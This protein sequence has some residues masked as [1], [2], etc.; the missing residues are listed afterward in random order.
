M[1]RLR[2]GI[3]DLV[4]KSPRPSLYGR[5]MNANLASIMPQVVAVWCEELGHDVTLVCYTGIEDLGRE[6]PADLDLL[7]IGAF[8][9]SAQLAYSLSNLYRSRGAVTA[10]G[11]P[12]ARCYP[13]DAQ[14]YFDY[15]L[16]FT[17]RNAIDE[18]LRDCEPHRPMGVQISAPRQPVELPTLQRRWK[19]VEAT[20]AKAPTIKI[21]PM[22]GSLGCPYTCCFC[23]DSTVEYQPLS[24]AQMSAD[25]KFLLTKFRNPIVGWHDPNFG[26]RFNDYMDAIEAAVPRGR[27]R[28]IAESSLSL[29]S[30]PHLQRLRDNGF[31][32]ILP[33][34]E[35]WYDLG[36]KSKTRRTGMD[37]VRQV[38][39]HVNMILRYIPY[40]QTN[41][42]LGMDT[43]DGPE[44]FELT[45][46]FIELSPGA[47]P[48]YSLLSAFGRAAPLNLDYQRAGRVLPF[49]FHFLNNNHA[50]NVRPL[51]YS[52]TEFYDAVV[53]VSRHS[54][55]W[56]AIARRI[57]ATATAIPKWMNFVRAVSSEGFGRIRYHTMMR[58]L[59]DTD[60]SVRDFFEGETTDLPEFY[61]Q[62]IEKEL[63]PLYQH[64]PEGALMH[65]PT[66]YLKS[67]EEQEPVQL[68]SVG[69]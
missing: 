50:M 36:N 39:D 6:L 48:A 14:K 47:F 13:E 68:R 62:R 46:K 11:G 40:I 22:I 1:R 33:G 3:L 30:E 26:V 23:I 34:I 66:A 56:R 25:L 60:R 53:Q 44:P 32:A 28:H 69:T 10:I 29:L 35:S 21:V 20:L 58:R 18:L 49:P 41:F 31:R 2:I 61:R 4:T 16:G 12:H 37:K 57:P 63:G 19:F 42:V 38:S 24:F 52:W 45:Q 15:V 55:S 64:L 51:N 8:T 65:D 54:F 27:M 7:F 43:D 59:L 17:D 5:I 9:Q 67:S